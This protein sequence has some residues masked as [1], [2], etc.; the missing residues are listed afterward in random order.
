MGRRMAGK[1]E[2]L[3]L[4]KTPSVAPEVVLYVGADCFFSTP[5]KNGGVSPQPPWVDMVGVPFVEALGQGR[6]DTYVPAE[7]ST[8]WSGLLSDL[9]ARAHNLAAEGLGMAHEGTNPFPGTVDG[10]ARLFSSRRL[11]TAVLRELDCLYAW[12]LSPSM[13]FVRG[14][15][16]NDQALQAWAA[17]DVPTEAL[18]FAAWVRT[19]PTTHTS[20]HAEFHCAY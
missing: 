3:P 7:H 15:R 9:Q 8:P 19:A 1:L 4:A 16:G 10:T 6:P 2:S 17:G 12:L 13:T 20:G 11:V 5:G 18:W 14:P